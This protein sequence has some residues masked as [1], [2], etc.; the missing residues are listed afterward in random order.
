MVRSRERSQRRHP[1]HYVERDI[2][3]ST[4][5]GHKAN[6][7]L[8]LRRVGGTC[9]G[10][11]DNR[12][13]CWYSEDMDHAAKS[14]V[15]PWVP[16]RGGRKRGP[17]LT[18]AEGAEIDGSPPIPDLPPVAMRLF[19][20]WLG[21]SFPRSLCDRYSS[22]SRRVS[23]SRMKQRIAACWRRMH[24]ARELRWAQQAPSPASAGAEVVPN[25]NHRRSCSPR[26]HPSVVK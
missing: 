13:C 12:R 5:K 16:L 22:R 2:V 7:R 21:F 14:L 18:T 1:I 17:R 26:A 23:L 24:S 25:M 15:A 3:P 19:S 20:C 4:A 11:R 10:G 8:D 6:I 9:F